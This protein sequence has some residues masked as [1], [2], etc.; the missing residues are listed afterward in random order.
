MV[1][2]LNGLLSRYFLKLIIVL[3][4]YSLSYASNA[5]DFTHITTNTLFKSDIDKYL[6]NNTLKIPL[7]FH[8]QP[9]FRQSKS[10]ITFA[11]PFPKGI[12]KNIELISLRDK[13]GNEIPSSVSRL[14]DWRD[15]HSNKTVS[16]RSVLFK[17]DSKDLTNRDSAY[18]VFYGKKRKLKKDID[19][20]PSQSWVTIDNGVY[21]DE[22]PINEQIKE[23][24]VYVTLPTDWLSACLLRTRTIPLGSSSGL[25]WFD[26]AYENYSKTAVND[27]DPRVTADNKIN[28]ASDAE[29]WLFDRAT[30]LFGIYIR[31]GDI[32]WLRHAHRAAQFYANHVSAEGFFDLKSYEDLKY[33]YGQSM[34][35]D[36]ML[37]GDARLL[38][39][40]EA[41]AKAGEGWNPVYTISRGFWTE[42]HQTYAL[43]AALSAWEATGNDRHAARVRE[44]VGASFGHALNP[45]NGWPA[46]GCMPHTR[47]SHEGDATHEAVCSPWMGALFADAIWRYY[48]HSNDKNALVFLG[49]YADFLVKYGTYIVSADVAHISGRTMPWYMASHEFQFSDSGPW[50]DYEHTCNVAGAMAKGMWAKKQLDEDTEAIKD[51]LEELLYSCNEVLDRWHRPRSINTG[52]PVWRLSPPRK[53]NWW[54]GTNLD[55]PWILSQ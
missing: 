13:N 9:S 22:Y 7:T 37:F 35:L 44:V 30:T 48:I 42:R 6:V 18:F 34:L 11:I 55:M 47:S 33:S 45:P 5:N 39:K 31:T 2:K 20:P 17:L 32:K 21:P 23:P 50:A 16:I 25:S 28:Y 51:T 24:A 49:D 52:N 1:L 4:V 40:I 15:L 26:T 3:L 10:I 12:A 27:V 46:I 19:T 29:P 41:V 8:F 53:Y 14:I 36:Y 38:P 54:F 43:L